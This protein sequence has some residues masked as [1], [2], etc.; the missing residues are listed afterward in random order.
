[1]VGVTHTLLNTE[2]TGKAFP[3]ILGRLNEEAEDTAGRNDPRAGEAEKGKEGVPCQ[4]LP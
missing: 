2:G 4:K 1:M 3:G